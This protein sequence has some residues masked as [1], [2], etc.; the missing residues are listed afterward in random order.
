MIPKDKHQCLVP[1]CNE[2][3]TQKL[4]GQH[5]F[6]LPLALRRR[7]WDETDW[8]KKDP[9]VELMTAIVEAHGGAYCAVMARHCVCEV[10]CAELPG[11]TA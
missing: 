6:K 11:A 5:W 4:C 10:R 9:G 7:W 1:G 2:P 8:G 3:T